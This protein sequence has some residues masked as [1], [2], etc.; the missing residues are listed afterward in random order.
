[1]TDTVLYY[2]DILTRVDT[3]DTNPL[4][5]LASYYEQ[6]GDLAASI[7]YREKIAQLSG[8]FQS[9]NELG[10]LQFLAG[11]YDDAIESFEQAINIEPGAENIPSYSGLADALNETGD[12][13]RQ[14]SVLDTLLTLDST[15]IPTHRRF[16]D[17]YSRRRFSD[18]ALI[19]S[20]IEVSLTPQDKLAIRR[21]GIIAYQADSLDL[22]A[23][24]FDE[25]IGIG[26]LDF[27]NYY[28]LGRI[29]FEKENYPYAMINFKTATRANDSVSDGWLGIGQ[30]FQAL[31]SLEQAAETYREGLAHVKESNDKLRLFFSLGAAQERM[32]EMKLSE[33]SFNEVLRIDSL[34]AP[35]L[36]YLGYMLIDR[37]DRVPY[38]KE[39]VR[40]ALEI[41]PNSGA[42][43]DSYAWALYREGKFEQARDSLQ[44][45]LELIEADPTLYDH[46]GDVYDKL[47]MPDSA[48]V[49]WRRALEKD[50]DNETIKS[51]LKQKSKK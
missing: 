47:G 41:N 46:L 39:L 19:H 43:I 48:T 23:E 31:D 6:L 4:K 50:T 14:R 26:Q 20:K 13:V 5:S 1:M 37:N 51:K 12:D 42:Y 10:A 30:T 36:N 35:A 2:L 44:R 38:A 34:N 18:S 11:R 22:A 25:L 45:A 8:D 29:F 3:T 16:I 28:F 33:K 9:Y 17:Y 7:P 21:L 27:T 15:H 40:K 24:Q 49:Y 32:G